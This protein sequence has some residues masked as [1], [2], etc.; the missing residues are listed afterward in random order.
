MSMQ[1]VPA[2]ALAFVHQAQ[3]AS[4]NRVRG[5]KAFQEGNLRAA[6]LFKA[7]AEAQDIHAKKT[8]LFLRG[9]IE[10]T[11]CNEAEAL[12][13]TRELFVD[14]L[15]WTILSLAEGDKAASALLTQ[16]ARTLKSHMDLACAEAGEAFYVCTI[17]GHIHAAADGEDGPG[18]CPVCQAVPEKFSRVAA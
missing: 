8:L 12:Q 6:G 1:T 13:E 3:A 10:D 15:E 4:K 17:C 16:M 18:R 5:Q 9:R 14:S 11:A 2:L 7:L